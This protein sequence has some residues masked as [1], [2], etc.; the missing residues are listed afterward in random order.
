V[1]GGRGIT[2]ALVEDWVTD[3]YDLALDSAPRSQRPART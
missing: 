1:G 3:S 2:A